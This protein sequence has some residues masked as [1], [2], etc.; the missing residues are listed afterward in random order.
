[1]E[2]LAL[3]TDIENLYWQLVVARERVA[4]ARQSLKLFEKNLTDTEARRAEGAAAKIDEVQA[5]QRVAQAQSALVD[6]MAA[7]KAVEDGIKTLAVGIDW[8]TTIIPT[9][10]M[11]TTDVIQADSNA[12]LKLA[13]EH[14]PEFRMISLAQEA[15]ARRSADALDATRPKLDIFAQ[16]S[17]GG[18]AGQFQPNFIDSHSPYPDQSTVLDSIANIADLNNR[19]ISAG[20]RYSF[21]FENT[22]AE[23]AASA[24]RLKE[25]QQYVAE[26]E[27]RHAVTSQIR[28]ALRAL[29]T[30]KQQFKA[31][32]VA[33]SLARAEY[34]AEMERMA[35]G[36]ST[37]FL[38]LEALL[39]LQAAEVALLESRQSIA[40][41]M[42][43]CRAAMGTTLEDRDI[44]LNA[45]Q[46]Q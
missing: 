30:A 13:E 21:N 15:S 23:F 41:A 12:L 27:I 26:Q 37:S 10:S 46:R 19:S 35:V 4:I 45:A 38:T 29:E 24:A 16:A 33:V 1:M 2:A 20:I 43:A 5:R 7:V 34:D 42:T 3:A 11:E 25:R 32:S 31:R 14:R 9:T 18:R 17:L 40:I 6:A 36:E 39:K 44:L 28:S 22:E 8:D